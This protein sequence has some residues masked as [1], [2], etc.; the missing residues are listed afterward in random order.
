MSS[1]NGAPRAPL[2]PK[3]I[4]GL[5]DDPHGYD[6]FQA[7]SL[8]EQLRPERAPVGEFADPSDEVVRFA[9]PATVGFP[10]SQIQRLE[11]G[12]GGAPAQMTVNFLGLVGPQGALPLD[13]TLYARS[14]ERVGDYALKDF[15]GLFEHRLISLFY[16]AWAKSH[17]VVG[18]ARDSAGDDQRTDATSGETGDWLTRQLSS[19][20]GL[21][22]RGLHG[23]QPM[24][25]EALLYYAGL[26]SVPS[27]PAT[28]LEQLVSDYFDVP[29]QVE[30]FVG[31]W[32][33]LHVTAQT[34]LG[35]GDGGLGSGAVAG[36][37][38]WDQQGRVRLRIGPLPRRRYD[39][40]LPGGASHDALKALTR[41]FGDD[42]FDFEI[43]LVLAR[44]ETPACRLDADDVPLP[45]GWATWLRTAPLDRDPDDAVFTL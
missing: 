45:L 42:Q 2:D 34:A 19:I 33:P 39:E 43:Q 21:S 23:E 15:I 18:F 12:E 37:E 20:V 1:T 32:Y 10:A 8:L 17:A 24:S 26:L 35:E 9:T 14:R 31:A 7:V 29:C 38:I 25:D 4:N 30:Q 3:L 6:F 27:R 22:T 11:E 5:L 44:D 16:R 13:Y 36:D 40:F 41:F 28:A